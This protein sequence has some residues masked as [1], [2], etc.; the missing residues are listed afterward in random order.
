MI[1]DKKIRII[2]L[3]SLG[4]SLA[5]PFFSVSYATQ[6][7]AEKDFLF[8]LGL[9]EE[10]KFDLAA[11]QF[12]RFIEEYP[13]SNL[14]SYAICFLG[15]IYYQKKEYARIISLFEKMREPPV[16]QISYPRRMEGPMSI[17]LKG[18]GSRKVEKAPSPTYPVEMEARGIEGKGR[19][20]IYV[21]PSG[22]VVNVEIIRSSGWLAFDK[23]I[24]E[25]L[26]KWKFSPVDEPAIE[27]YEGEFYFRFVK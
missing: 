17:A 5:I 8:A 6:T 12:Q 2:L 9:Y 24:R 26:L 19:V 7:Q 23:E 14:V 13:Q 11:E 22:E 27:V 3:L 1:R 16:P 25:T 20:R 15:Y 21:A 10:G 18:L 4:L